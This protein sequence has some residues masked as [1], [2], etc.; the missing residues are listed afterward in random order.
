MH[1]NRF[2]RNVVTIA[3]IATALV[4][5]TTVRAQVDITS[6]TAARALSP[7]TIDGR[8]DD[9]DWSRAAEGVLTET[10]TGNAVPLKSTVKVLWDDQFLYV[11][12]HFEDPDAWATI[13]SEDG[14]LWGEEVAEVFIDPEGLGHTYYE[15]EINPVNTKVDLFVINAGEARNGVYKVWK[16]WDF[17]SKLKQAVYVQGDG[18]RENTA[19]EYWSVEVAFP[20]EDIWTAPNIPPLVGDTWRIGFYRIE[21]GKSG[22]TPGDDWYAALSPGLNPSFHRPWRFAKVTFSDK[23]T[24]VKTVREEPAPFLT[25]ANYPNPF[26]PSTTIEFTLPKEG[27]VALSVYNSMGQKVRE[28]IADTMTP[29]L[30]R[31]VW[32]GRDDAGRS[33]SSGTYLYRVAGPGMS[34]SGKMELV[35]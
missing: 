28:L 5:A 22:N 29:G 33:V 14:A 35:R 15:H 19:D 1:R 16:N 7:L 8:L 12:F 23:E 27:H 20:F 17:S 25:S 31:V 2:C 6:Y 21:R 9:P 11:G 30:Y 3:G 4:F 18:L 32:D 34:A 13:T 24:G 10:N 26:N